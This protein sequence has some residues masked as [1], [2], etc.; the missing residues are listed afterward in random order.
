MFIFNNEK[1]KTKGYV[2]MR[3]NILWHIYL[4]EPYVAFRKNQVDLNCNG[5]VSLILLEKKHV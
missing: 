1:V 3:L 2:K 5:I 4:M